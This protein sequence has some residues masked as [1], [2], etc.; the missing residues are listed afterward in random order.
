MA[1]PWARIRWCRGACQARWESSGEHAITAIER[2]PPSSAPSCAIP[3]GPSLTLLTTVTPARARS[4]VSVNVISLAYGVSPRLPTIATLGLA[5]ESSSRRRS[6]LHVA[7]N[8]AG[9]LGNCS[10]ARG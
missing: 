1:V 5:G 6:A 9:A 3:S 2:P 7:Y 4:R 10:S 8:T